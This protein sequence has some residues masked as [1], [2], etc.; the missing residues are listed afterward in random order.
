MSM[1][2]P[3]KQVNVT[4][5]GRKYSGGAEARTLLVYFL[6][7]E[8]G[9]TGT[10][11]GCIVG[12]CGACSIMLDGKLVKS[13]LLFAQQADGAEILTVEG[14][15][16]GQE[17]HPIQEAFWEQHGLQCGY[18]TPGMLLATYS[19]LRE[20][21]DP[22]EEEIREGISGNLCM[23][24]GYVNIVR[25][26]KAAAPK[27]MMMLRPPRGRGRTK[28]SSAAT[29]SPASVLSSSHPS[30]S[31]RQAGPLGARGRSEKKQRRKRS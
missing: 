21:P 19:L 16:N 7:E 25:A 3:P 23:C 13:C 29:A 18:C 1:P 28:S 20:I 31:A 27:M 5:N 8:L 10:H 14:L 9:L 17:L 4:V 12:K 11:I 26:I 15:A 24:T 22:S 2:S 30:P 6:R